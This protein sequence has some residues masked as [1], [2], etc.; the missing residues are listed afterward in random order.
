ME[1]ALSKGL[2]W[3]LTIRSFN[4]DAFSSSPDATVA[5]TAILSVEAL[6]AWPLFIC[7]DFNG[8]V[9]PD[10]VVQ[11]SATQWNIL[12][13]TTDGRWFSPE[14]AMTFETPLKGYFEI[15]DLNGDGRSD[16]VLRARDDP[17]LVIFLTEPPKMKGGHP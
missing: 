5:L 13:S 12:F 10:F 7:G 15:K 2:D 17:R 9:R 14:P 8:D 11:R 1:M 6:E 3:T 16:I 4:H